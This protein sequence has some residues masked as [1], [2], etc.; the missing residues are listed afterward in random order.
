MPY[1]STTEE[2]RAVQQFEEQ[3]REWVRFI[4]SSS[5]SSRRNRSSTVQRNMM[6]RCPITTTSRRA[7]HRVRT[8]SRELRT[9]QQRYHQRHQRPGDEPTTPSQTTRTQQTT[10]LRAQVQ[11]D[12][13]GV[14]LE[15]V[16]VQRPQL[17]VHSTRYFRTES[18]MA[19]CTGDDDRKSTTL[20]RSIQTEATKS[21]NISRPTG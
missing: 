4:A 3:I 12:I 13:N 8:G 9:E 21:E 19:P 17:R 7:S 10:I 5:K 20:L 16:D 15:T 18:M 6:G 2:V 11:R 14:V 1:Q